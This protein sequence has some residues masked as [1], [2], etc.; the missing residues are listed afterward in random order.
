[1]WDMQATEQTITEIGSAGSRAQDPACTGGAVHALGAATAAPVVEIVVP[2]YNEESTL[3]RSIERLHDYLADAFPFTWRITIV[4]NGS[5]DRTWERASDGV[6]RFDHVA[7]L[8]LDRK[9]RGLA[10][11]TAW[12]RSDAAVVAYMDVDLSTGLEALLPLVAPLISGHSDVAI[13]SRLSPGSRVVRGPKREL[14]S[15]TYNRMLRTVFAARFRDAQCGFKAV[16]ADV[17][18][19]LLPEIADDGWFFDTELLLL[20]AHNGLRIHEVPVDWVDDPD[21]RVKL[22]STALGDLAGLARMALRFATGQGRIDPVATENTQHPDELARRRTTI[23]RVLRCF[24]V[25]VGTTLLSAAILAGL[26]VLAG[27]PAGP[28][29]ILAVM[30]GIVP[31]YIFNRRWVWG[32]HGRGDLWREVVPFWT[33]SIAGLVASTATVTAVASA[34]AGLPGG[35]RSVFLAAANATTF[36]FL[37]VAQFLLLDHVIFAEGRTSDAAPAPAQMNQMSSPI[38]TRPRAIAGRH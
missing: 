9:G 35:W 27:V 26:V 12:A 37:W 16:R 23:M 21:S 13:G 36:A 34:T 6:E 2:V 29:N 5:T 32:R 22:V 28:A 19:R 17:A 30:C 20:A 24:A 33:L 7:A 18:K 4:D 11:R 1:M 3:P 25:S 15:R 14:I 31:S 38:H 10:L 8:R